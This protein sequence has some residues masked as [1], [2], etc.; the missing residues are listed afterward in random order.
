MKRLACHF[1]L[2]CGIAGLAPV[3]LAGESNTNSI[4]AAGRS[5]RDCSQPGPARKHQRQPGG[6]GRHELRSGGA[7]GNQFR[8]GGRDC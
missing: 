5:D 7:G 1:L 3:G 2:C 6:A 8:S 4:A